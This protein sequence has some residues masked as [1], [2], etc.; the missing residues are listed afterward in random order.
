MSAD[1]S[2][3]CT[4]CENTINDDFEFCPYCGTV[5]LEQ[6]YCVNHPQNE[7]NGICLICESA[8]CKKCGS[9]AYDKFF[10]DKHGAYEV[11]QGMAKIYGSG[12]LFE[13]ENLKNILET[14]GMHPFIFSRKSNTDFPGLPEYSLFKRI[15]NEGILLNEFKLLLPFSEVLIGEEIITGIDENYTSTEES[16]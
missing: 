11:Y 2:F 5:F 4:R 7:A 8:F 12:D 3:T 15:D 9:Y 14:E 1:S 6:V 16:G 13:I 10:C